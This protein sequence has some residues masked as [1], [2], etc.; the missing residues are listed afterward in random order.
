MILSTCSLSG[1]RKNLAVK[2]KRGRWWV[3]RH[4]GSFKQLA[5]YKSDNIRNIS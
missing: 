3:Q 4:S 5:F 1:L 2:K